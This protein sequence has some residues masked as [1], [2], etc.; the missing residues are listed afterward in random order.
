MHAMEGGDAFLAIVAI[1]ALVTFF[2]LS[3]LLPS[4]NVSSLL[5]REL[6][7]QHAASKCSRF[8]YLPRHSAKIHRRKRFAFHWIVVM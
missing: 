7:L 1:L 5:C 6:S 8:Q 2:L 3:D 4:S